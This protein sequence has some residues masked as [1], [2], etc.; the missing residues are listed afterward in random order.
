MAESAIS[1]LIG[2]ELAKALAG[3]VGAIALLEL[4]RVGLQKRAQQNIPVQQAGTPVAI[5]PPRHLPEA[6]LAVADNKR[7]GVVKW[8]AG[9]QPAHKA[10]IVRWG[11]EQLTDLFKIEPPELRTAVIAAITGPT[12]GDHFHRV[13][14]WF[15]DEFIKLSPESMAI[16][17]EWDSWAKDILNEP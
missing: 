6:L 9:L 2:S 10:E 7:E 4:V 8:V 16:L 13:L 11:K 5:P 15:E 14:K 12:A 3:D 1:K 17:D